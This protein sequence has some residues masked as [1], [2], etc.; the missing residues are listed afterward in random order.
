MWQIPDVHN[1]G[2]RIPFLRRPTEIPESPAPG[3]PAAPVV[4]EAARER[5]LLRAEAARLADPLLARQM[6]F[7]NRSWVPP[8]EGGEVRAGED[9]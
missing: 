8:R 5:E 1:P 3:A 4:D 2:M 6:R 9:E 7:A